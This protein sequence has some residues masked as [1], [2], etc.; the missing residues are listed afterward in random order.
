MPRPIPVLLLPEC[1]KNVANVSHCPALA[2]AHRQDTHRCGNCS[3]G[4]HQQLNF[5]PRDECHM[6]NKRVVSCDVKWASEEQ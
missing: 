6:F 4:S 1:S 2:P 5:D 3:Q